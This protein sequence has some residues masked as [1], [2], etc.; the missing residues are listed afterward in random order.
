MHASKAIARLR[1]SVFAGMTASSTEHPAITRARQRLLGDPLARMYMEEAI[2]QARYRDRHTP[3]DLEELLAQLNAVLHTA[4]T[5]IPPSAGEAAA[6]VG[7]PFSAALL[8]LMGTPAGFSAFR[9]PLIND[10]S[11]DLRAAWTDYLDSPQSAAVLNQSEN[12]W[13]SAAAQ[14]SLHMSDYV[15]QADAPHWGFQSWNDSLPEGLPK[16]LAQSPHPQIRKWS[17]RRVIL[18]FTASPTT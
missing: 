8:W 16:G 1:D 4:P 17:P 3:A 14:A 12:G 5:C 15:Y 9:Y 7:T 6:L 11:R 2:T 18:R 13:M 10:V